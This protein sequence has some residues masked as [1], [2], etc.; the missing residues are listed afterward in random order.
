MKSP[1]ELARAFSKFDRISWACSKKLLKLRM[2]V[3]WIW[4]K[5]V[6]SSNIF[7]AAWMEPVM[8]MILEIFSL[9]HAWLILHL[10]AKSSA[11]V[12]VMKAVW[13]TI[14]IKEWSHMWMCK[15]NVAILFLMLAS[16][17]TIAMWGED[18]EWSIILSSCWKCNLL[19]FTLLA[20]LKETQ[21]EKM[22]TILE[23]GLNSRLRG[24]MK[25]KLQK[26]YYLSQ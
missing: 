21:L 17:T 1:L 15:T 23:S 4:Y 26:V 24:K 2:T 16:V 6:L 7:L 11:S 8:M 18:N 12:L 10:M 19:L 3:I 20:K 13:W 22:F 9:L 14:L 25:G 5:W